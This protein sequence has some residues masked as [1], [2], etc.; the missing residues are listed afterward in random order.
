MSLHVQS[1]ATA[2]I[3]LS[4]TE[5]LG[6]LEGLGVS[7]VVTDRD[8]TILA[9]NDSSSALLGRSA[10]DVL[11]RQVADVMPMDLRES[12]LHDIVGRSGD[13]MRIQILAVPAGPNRDLVLSLAIPADGDASA[14]S[15]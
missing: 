13:R 14:P 8:G 10:A 3:D 7:V 1:D 6:G 4:A 15:G 12:G 9:W 5:V 11:G 2:V